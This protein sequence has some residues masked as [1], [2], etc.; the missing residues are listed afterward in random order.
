[1]IHF[2]F[3]GFIKRPLMAE[4]IGCKFKST[5]KLINTVISATSGV[6]K[7]KTSQE[8]TATAQDDEY[9]VV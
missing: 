5:D 9:S 6:K 4:I 2:S 7:H 1:M 8:E 3:T